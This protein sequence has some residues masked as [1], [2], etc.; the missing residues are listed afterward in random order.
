MALKIQQAFVSAAAML[1]AAA[2]MG[3]IFNAVRPSGIP[4]IG[5]WSPKTLTMLHAGD[6]ETIDAD[7]AFELFSGEKVMFID[8]RDK[9]AFA[10]GHIPGAVNITLEEA[11][12]HLDEVRA[13]LKTG[14]TLVA[15]CYD[16]D[17]PLAADLVKK[18]RD[19]G[20]GPVRVMTE[21]WAGWLD[22][23]YPDE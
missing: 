13:M 3:M 7:G 4:L 2:A 20:I 23:G 6:L 12:R 8:V 19:L 5:D 14:K 1:I 16:L 10:A 11:H 18:L 9:D 15:Y 21:G 17:C 22:R